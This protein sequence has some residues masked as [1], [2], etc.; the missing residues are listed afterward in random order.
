MTFSEYF[1]G[2]LPKKNLPFTI[3][4][5]LE[6]G[7]YNADSDSDEDDED[8]EYCDN[9]PEFS[10]WP[11]GVQYPEWDSEHCG[12]ESRSPIF[13]NP[14]KVDAY[15][16]AFFTGVKDHKLKVSDLCG[17]H[18]HVGL[19]GFKP[20]DL[21]LTLIAVNLSQN[22]FFRAVPEYRHNNRFCLRSND[23]KFKAYLQAVRTAVPLL[24]KGEEEYDKV[25]AELPPT[26]R[27]QSKDATQYDMYCNPGH[28]VNPLSDLSYRANT[29]YEACKPKYAAGLPMLSPG[30]SGVTYSTPDLYYGWFRLNVDYQ[31]L[32]FR[33]LPTTC[34]QK[35]WTAY[36][37]LVSWFMFRLRTDAKGCLEELLSHSDQDIIN[38]ELPF[39]D[40]PKSIL[41]Q[42]AKFKSKHEYPNQYVPVS[43]QSATAAA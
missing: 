23:Q 42:Y 29:I 32:E 31:T 22:F 4:W 9:V 24:F 39:S 34:D 10:N 12:I 11:R 41:K 21:A 19:D 40:W 5:E 8:Y 13:S 1:E 26:F 43:I 28:F 2:R 30:P 20:K 27:P 6:Y 36:L 3:G 37:A 14:V 16:G 18:L 33:L 15:L 25:V 38:G 35:T 7:Y 17:G